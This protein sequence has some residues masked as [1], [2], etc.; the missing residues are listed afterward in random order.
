MKKL[1]VPAKNIYVDDFSSS[2]NENSDKDFK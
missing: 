1:R 2:E